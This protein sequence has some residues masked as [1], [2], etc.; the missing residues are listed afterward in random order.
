MLPTNTNNEDSPRASTEHNRALIVFAHGEGDA[1]YYT[2][3]DDV[4]QF[5]QDCGGWAESFDTINCGVDFEYP[6]DG[7]FVAEMKIVDDGPGDWPGSRESVLQLC[8]M[9]PITKDEWRAWLNADI[10]WLTED[11]VP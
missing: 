7:V 8:D 9:R 11:N 4:Q 6:G 1:L 5:I 2:G 3:D 10:F